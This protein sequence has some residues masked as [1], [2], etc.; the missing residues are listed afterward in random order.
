MA[1]PHISLESSAFPAEGFL[2]SFNNSKQTHDMLASLRSGVFHRRSS[3]TA[4]RWAQADLQSRIH[5]RSNCIAA[6]SPSLTQFSGHGFHHQP[7][8]ARWYLCDACYQAFWLASVAIGSTVFASAKPCLAHS[9]RHCCL[10][11]LPDTVNLIS[12]VAPSPPSHS[13]LRSKWY[14]SLW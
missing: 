7:T 8:E 1:R 11:C 9:P 14:W 2:E 13:P 12:R 3:R 6:H 10:F 5:K 4:H